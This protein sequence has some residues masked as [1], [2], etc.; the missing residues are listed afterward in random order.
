MF[1]FVSVSIE[2]KKSLYSN[3]FFSLFK[4]FALVFFFIF[5]SNTFHDLFEYF[6][7]GTLLIRIR[8]WTYSNIFLQLIS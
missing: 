7:S 5:Y 3:N 2:E 4:Y 6:S 1:H 8:L